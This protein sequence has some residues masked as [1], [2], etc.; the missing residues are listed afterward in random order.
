MFVNLSIQ[1]H[2]E[3]GKDPGTMTAL[4]NVVLAPNVFGSIEPP[5]P[6]QATLNDTTMHSLSFGSIYSSIYISFY[7]LFTN[8]VL[9][10]S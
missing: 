3:I 9:I 4:N 1:D 7:V 5:Q 10:F 8:G 2:N 6:T